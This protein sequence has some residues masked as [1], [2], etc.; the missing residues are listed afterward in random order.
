MGYFT[1]CKFDSIAEMQDAINTVV[2]RHVTAMREVK[3]SELGLDERCGKAWVDEDT[4]VTYTSNRF[5]YY[6]GFEYVDKDDIQ[7][8]GEYKFYSA[9]SSRIADALECLMEHD[10]ECESEDA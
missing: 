9:N 4:I 7:V 6:G 1:D 2:D 8:L 10:G 5:D 3:A